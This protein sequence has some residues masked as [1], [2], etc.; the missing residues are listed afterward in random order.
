MSN[1]IFWIPPLRTIDILG[2]PGC[3]NS[4][5]R[6]VLISLVTYQNAFQYHIPPS[7]TAS[8]VVSDLAAVRR[9]ALETLQDMRS[10]NIRYAELRTTPRPLADG[11]SP[12]DYIVAVLEVFRDF[13]TAARSTEAHNGSPLENGVP[14]L[15]PRLLLSMDRGRTIDDA[16][17]VTELALKLHRDDLWRTYVV[18]VDFSGNPTKGTF[19]DF[20]SDSL[21]HWCH[22]RSFLAQSHTHRCSGAAIK[23]PP[24]P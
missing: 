15:I 9:I 21:F 24:R 10:H 5:A 16:V 6:I 20:R 23:F 12:Q 22:Y 2:A 4:T 1:A 8:R 18:G 3:S 19:G 17:A 11:T 14:A 13:E 7:Y